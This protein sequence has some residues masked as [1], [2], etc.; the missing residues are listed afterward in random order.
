MIFIISILFFHLKTVAAPYER[1]EE[2]GKFGVKNELGTVII[3]AVYDALG[4]SNGSFSVTGKVTGYKLNGTWGIVNIN[5]ERVTH[6]DYLSLVP[7]DGSLIVATKKSSAI[8][9]HAG[10][11]NTEGKT[12]IPFTY[13]GVKVHSLRIVAFIR[14]GNQFKHGLISLENKILIPFQYKNIYPIGS[15]RL[16]V[17]NFN[18]KIALFSEGGKQISG[19]T[20]DSLSDFRNNVAILYENGK[21][22]LINRD[23]QLKSE[24]RF[25]EIQITGEGVRA[26]MPDEWLALSAENKTLD[27]LEGDSITYLKEDRYKIK[28]GVQSWLADK[29]LKKIKDQHALDIYPFENRLAVFKTKSGYGVL[30]R[31]GTV[32]L[33]PVFKKIMFD[34]GFILT[35]DD[36]NTWSLR[37]TTGLLKTSKLYEII[38]KENNGLFTAMRKNHWGALDGTGREVVA[39]VYDSVLQTGNNQLAVKFKGLYGIINTKEEW[40]VYPQA[41][42]LAL[43]NSDRYFKKAGKTLFLISFD[44]TVLYFTDN[45]IKVN[46]ENFTEYIST[47]GSW[48]I[49]FDGKIASRQLPPAETTEKVFP[50]SEGLR[51]IKRNGKYGF[52]DDLGRLRIAN[53][54]EDIKPFSEGLAAFKI[55]NKWGFINRDEKIII[56]PAYDDI[57]P[58]ASEHAIIKQKGLYGYMD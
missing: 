13:A 58:F 34:K 47:G 38:H 51:G 36:N 22:G 30:K 25:R 21:Q 42:R 31:N 2:N 11:I 5:N 8:A 12:I 49:D 9:V 15:L 55:R 35:Q 29:N 53:R 50:A 7:A 24:A 48:T 32:L 45:P 40:L 16:A 39:C 26:R 37:D 54:Y 14:E 20:I 56:Q 1:F 17:E 6:A 44:G 41:H 3:P 18:G 19:F 46:S 10:L 28:S 4:W 23:G 27:V 52:I 57:T 43:L 33:K